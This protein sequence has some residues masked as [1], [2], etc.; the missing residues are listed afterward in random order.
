M[1]DCK[2]G[3]V[4]LTLIVIAVRPGMAPGQDADGQAGT[5]VPPVAAGPGI[6]H[7]VPDAVAR[8]HP[9]PPRRPVF[10]PPDFSLKVFIGHS[11]PEAQKEAWQPIK[12]LLNKA[13]LG[14]PDDRIAYFQTVILP[15]PYARQVW[16]WSGL[17]HS[18]KKV[19]GGTVVELRITASQSGMVDTANIIERYS[20]LNGKIKYLGFY[21]PNDIPRVQ[22]GF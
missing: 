7:I 12:D 15:E 19:K 22:V 20:I 1:L 5:A 6:P 11:T 8:R 17:I 13:R 10:V 9:T 16:G 18:V 3:F 14:V 2:F 21:V 4:A